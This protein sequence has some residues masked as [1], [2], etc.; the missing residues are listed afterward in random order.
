MAGTGCGSNPGAKLLPGENYSV[1]DANTGTQ[2]GQSLVAAI[3]RYE[4]DHE[5]W[6]GNLNELVPD[7]TSVDAIKVWR[8]HTFHHDDFGLCYLGPLTGGT[9][10]F[11]H[12]SWHAD[13]WQVSWGPSESGTTDTLDVEPTKREPSKLTAEQRSSRKYVLLQRRIQAE[14]RRINHRTGLMKFYWDQSRFADAKQVCEQCIETWPDYWWSYFMLAKIESKL[15]DQSG[16][17]RRLEM[18]AERW[19]DFFGY[20]F[21]AQFHFDRNDFELC[22]VALK[23]AVDC[24]PCQF[25]EQY[26]FDQIGAHESL[27]GDCHY[28]NAAWLAYQMKDRDLCLAVCERWRQYCET[29]QRYGGVE[30][31][32]MRVVCAINA[33]DW[34][35]AELLLNG[36]KIHREKASW[37]DD[38]IERLRSQ[39]EQKNTKYQYDPALFRKT[40][41]PL[42]LE[43]DYK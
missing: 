28:H 4:A 12:R 37:Q 36:M 30:E 34:S 10:H 23:Q 39:I 6:P 1:S 14:P 40:G 11:A 24:T 13:H 41:V 9:L 19:K 18:L 15:G 29:I 20:A 33:S 26:E 32:A 8:Y 31:R 35:N 27:V 25:K 7:Y 38:G 5:C 3:Y 43:F 17:Q 21:L 2:L 42:T 16:S 22:K